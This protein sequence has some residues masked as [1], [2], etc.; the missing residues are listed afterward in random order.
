MATE[1]ELRVDLDED[2]PAI[3]VMDAIAQADPSQSR[4][5]ITRRVLEDW[6]R[7]ELHRASLIV[8]VAGRHGSAAESSRRGGG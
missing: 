5:S 1:L 7:K 3:A 8:R 4:S 6:A 2:H